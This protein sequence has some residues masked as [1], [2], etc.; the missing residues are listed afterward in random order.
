MYGLIQFQITFFVLFTIVAIREFQDIIYTFLFKPIFIDK[1]K[2]HCYRSLFIIFQ[3]PTEL[4]RLRYYFQTH[5]TYNRIPSSA[6]LL[7]FGL[8][9]AEK[10]K[11]RF[12]TKRY[13]CRS[14]L[15]SQPREIKNSDIW[16]HGFCNKYKK[17]KI[18]LLIFMV[19]RY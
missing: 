3:K 11:Y 17:I 15:S 1:C 14:M 8:L 12:D 6:E 5:Q 4:C 9:K 19:F 7:L 10:Y 16:I 2:Y 18:Y 13:P